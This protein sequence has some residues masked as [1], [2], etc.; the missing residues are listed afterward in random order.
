MSAND[1]RKNFVFKKET[2]EH[3]KE[4]AKRDGKSM[5]M[6]VQ[7]LIE[8]KYQEISVEEKLEAIDAFFALTKGCF[9]EGMTIQ[10]IKAKRGEKG[11]KYGS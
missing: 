1:V 3:L 5:T 10:K 2:A 4:L 8:N 6:I 9:E 7:E 11:E